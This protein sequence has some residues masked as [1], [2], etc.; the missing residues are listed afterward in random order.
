M[1]AA[2]PECGELD[3]T[4]EPHFAV[5]LNKMVHN[6]RI[7]HCEF[8]CLED[9]TIETIGDHQDDCR[10]RPIRCPSFGRKVCDFLGN[11]DQ[12]IQ[13]MKQSPKCVEIVGA[14]IYGTSD[15]VATYNGELSDKNMSALEIEAG[16]IIWRPRLL[17]DQGGKLSELMVFLS[18]QRISGKGV[19][20]VFPMSLRNPQ[21]ADK[22][23][24]EVKIVSEHNFSETNL[25]YRGPCTSA[26]LGEDWAF[27][28]ARLI[29]LSD[30]IVESFTD[31]S[32]YF[33]FQVT[34]FAPGSTT[35]Y[36]RMHKW[37]TTVDEFI[38]HDEPKPKRRAL[39]LD[40]AVQESNMDLDL[41]NDSGISAA[42][43]PEVVELE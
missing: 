40:I 10:Q 42:G 37:E 33:A 2:C 1:D 19:W 27:D 43:T 8:G 41:D 25:L 32:K 36:Q 17:E 38:H 6:G 12:L 13:H 14:N 5:A 9:F 7:F 21:I 20:A 39:S 4:I 30:S 26:H 29:F 11:R 16:H 3:F 23:F 24:L 35:E 34:L 31:E 15:R 22:I 18:C 28:N